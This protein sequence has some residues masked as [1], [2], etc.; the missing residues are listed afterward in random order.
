MDS[1]VDKKHPVWKT[2]IW[3]G[4]MIA[5]IAGTA[6]FLMDAY[7]Q[8]KIASLCNDLGSHLPPEQ[9]YDALMKCEHEMMH[10]RQFGE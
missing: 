1:K 5:I 6:S 4:I 9:Q 2:L 10:P 7:R 8:Q 3:V